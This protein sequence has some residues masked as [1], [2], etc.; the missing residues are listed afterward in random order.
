MKK[1]SFS[2]FAALLLCATSSSLFAQKIGIEGPIE[3]EVVNT[4]TRKACLTG[5]QGCATVPVTLQ[6]SGIFTYSQVFTNTTPSVSKTFHAD[7][8]K[9]KVSIGTLSST[10]TYTLPTIIGDATVI[11][12]T[13]G[14]TGGGHGYTVFITKTADR[15]FTLA[16]SDNVL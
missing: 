10:G 1:K 6:L 7:G 13:D 3:I 14:L 15:Q 9:I 12:A 5:Y 2:L 11:P 8:N 16:V 4:V